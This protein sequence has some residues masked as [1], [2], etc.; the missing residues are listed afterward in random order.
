MPNELFAGHR[1][2]ALGE[3]RELLVAYGSREPEM[4][5]KSS[6]PLPLYCIALRP[7]LLTFRGELK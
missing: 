5:S 4:V 3:S 6:L 2:L 7:I 1:M